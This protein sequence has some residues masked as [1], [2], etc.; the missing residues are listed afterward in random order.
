MAPGPGP[1]A[2]SRAAAALGDRAHR[3]PADPALVVEALAEGERRDVAVLVQ[4]LVGDE[5]R[6]LRSDARAFGSALRSSRS[7]ANGRPRRVGDVGLRL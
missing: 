6:R 4:R 2:S 1:A 7:R 3:D 5:G